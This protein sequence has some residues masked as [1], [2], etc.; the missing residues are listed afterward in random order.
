MIDMPELPEVEHV[1]RTLRPAVLGRTVTAVDLRRPDIVTGSSTPADLLEGQRVV[2]LRR[3]G[4]QLALVADTGRCVVV[5]LGMSGRLL[6]LRPGVRHEAALSP[7]LDRH[8]H[9]IWRL[10]S[11]G[12]VVF[13]DPRRFGGLWTFASDADLHTQRWG[14]LGPDALAI[15]P[16]A[17]HDRLAR[18]RRP[19]KA[20]LLDQHLVAG[21]GNIY[22]D[23]LLFACRLSPTTPTEAV[24][25]ATAARLVRHMRRILGKAIDAGGSTLRD[26]VGADGRVGGY[27]RAHRVY[28]QGGRRCPRAACRSAL[29]TTIVAGRTTTFCPVC[30]ACAAA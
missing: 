25:R 27:Q 20:A 30:Q 21:L 18:T 10:D 1:G 16:A 6:S 2:D 23:E 9:A 13:A 5:H 7:P 15:G 19:L 17:L 8:M 3:H 4:K 22:V 28:G 29:Q 14:V 11:G 24:N 12:H 26:F